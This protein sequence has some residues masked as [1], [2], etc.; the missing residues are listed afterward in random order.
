MLSATTVRNTLVEITILII[1]LISL[2]QSEKV[3]TAIKVKDQGFKPRIF[4]REAVGQ[5]IKLPWI[6]KF[7]F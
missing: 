6:A 1:M 2:S 7:K 4:A 3:S 5:R